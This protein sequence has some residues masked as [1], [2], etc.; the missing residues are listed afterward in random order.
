MKFLY[1]VR[2]AKAI[3]AELGINDFK[4]TLSKQGLED[5]K[6]MGKRMKKKGLFPDLLLSSPADRTLETA[7]IFAQQI[8]YP[9]S[10]VLL[11]DEF[12]DEDL[13]IILEILKKVSD[14]DDSLM[15]FG[16]EP[17]LSQL[18]VLF[19]KDT[20]LELRTSGVL[21][22]ALEI[23]SW[24]ELDEGAGT[25]VFFDFPVRAT[26]KVYKK[27]RKTIAAEISA[28][29]ESLLEDLDSGSAKHLEK[30][31]EKTSKKLAKQ[32][33]QVLHASKVEDIAKVKQKKQRIDLREKF[34]QELLEGD[35]ASEASTPPE[36]QEKQDIETSTNRQ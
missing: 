3:S 21:G 24:Q 22:I 7:H 28:S 4:R 26:P 6:A 9:V 20:E 18:A 12:Y 23:E 32:L 34:E 30:I 27:A 16:H 10:K 19:L 13:G 31:L 1:L 25:L 29:M 36:A 5:A 8:G 2:H 11:K 15:L 14:S 17:V 33:T 35:A